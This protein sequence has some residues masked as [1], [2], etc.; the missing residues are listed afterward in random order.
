MK[1]RNWIYSF[2]LAASFVFLPNASQAFDR[3]KCLQKVRNLAQKGKKTRAVNK[4]FKCS[5]NAI[6]QRAKEQKKSVKQKV[7]ALKKA[8]PNF[9][10]AINKYKKRKLA[11]I[12]ANK[13]AII[14]R[15]KDIQKSY[16][17]R[18]KKQ[19][20]SAREILQGYHTRN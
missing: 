14:K 6:R 17:K 4:S 13:K 3:N 11:S 9:K 16:N 15:T 12:E 5:N 19:K 20:K 18:Q 10:S 8:H 1:I 2:I 7:K